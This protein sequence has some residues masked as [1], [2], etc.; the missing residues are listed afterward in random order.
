MKNFTI[1]FCVMVGFLMG[2]WFVGNWELPEARF[3]VICAIFLCIWN[4]IEVHE[5]KKLAKKFTGD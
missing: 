4:L 5:L 1:A 2:A 3:M